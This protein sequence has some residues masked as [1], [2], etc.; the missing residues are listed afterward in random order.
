MCNNNSIEKYCH[1]F[2]TNSIDTLGIA[3]D[4]VKVYN[5]K[6]K[7]VLNYVRNMFEMLFKVL[8][9]NL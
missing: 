1:V 3:E 6:R 4:N 2:Q 8:F 7:E 9:R 5:L